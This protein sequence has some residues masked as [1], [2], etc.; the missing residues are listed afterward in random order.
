M[1]LDGCPMILA[2]LRTCCCIRGLQESNHKLAG[3]LGLARQAVQTRAHEE[4]QELQQ[5]K[6]HV[7][8]LSSHNMI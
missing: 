8:S 1:N 3:E 6:L 4:Q 2:T 5:V 7:R